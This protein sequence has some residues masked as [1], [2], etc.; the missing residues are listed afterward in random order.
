MTSNIHLTS[1]GTYTKISLSL[2][3]SNYSCVSEAICEG[4]IYCKRQQ[5]LDTSTLPQNALSF[6]LSSFLPASSP[7]FLNI[8]QQ[9]FAYGTSA[10][11]SQHIHGQPARG[12]RD[13]LGRNH[14]LWAMWILT[15][16]EMTRHTF[17]Q[18]KWDL[19][20]NLKYCSRHSSTTRD[21]HLRL[22]TVTLEWDAHERGKWGAWKV[23]YILDTRQIH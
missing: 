3:H 9:R 20:L 16:I 6:F 7:L 14:L 12:S 5:A 23:K 19:V 8:H 1:S 17:E 13:L 11:R 21:A 22:C 2:S 4:L 10:Q 15:W 18:F